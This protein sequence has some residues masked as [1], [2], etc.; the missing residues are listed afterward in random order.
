MLQGLLRSP[1]FLRLLARFVH[2]FNIKALHFRNF[3]VLFSWPLVQETLH[4]D[5]DFRIE[6]ING[7]RM[8]G[9]AGPFYLG[10]VRGPMS[11]DQR[12]DC[13]HAMCAVDMGEVA[14]AIE[15]DAASV[16]KAPGEQW[17]ADHFFQSLNLH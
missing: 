9:V 3:L 15:A 12:D 10:L 8:R 1:A 5:N 17:L 2:T 7:E 13:G 11:H 6:P 4:R 14:K 16:S